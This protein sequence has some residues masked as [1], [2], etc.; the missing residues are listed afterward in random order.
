ML[1][2]FALIWAIAFAVTSALSV[3]WAAPRPIEPG[4]VQSQQFASATGCGCHA[5]LVDQWSTSM[6]AKALEDPIYKVKKAE[7][8][9]ATG[10]QLGAFCDKCHG[11]IATA[12]G[13]LA[14]GGALS[15]VSAQS[16]SC[17]FCHQVI[18]LAPGEPGN[19]SHLVETDGVRRA[20]LQDPAAPHPA[21]YSEFH[22]SA[23][24]CGGCHNVNHPVNGMHLESTYSEWKA[25]AYAEEGIVCQ[26]CHMSRAPGEIGPYTAAAASSAVQRDN[27]YSMMF[28]G[29]QVALGPSKLATQRLK[30]AATMEVNAPEV[31]APG[32]DARVTVTITNSGA[33]HYLP[34]GLTEVRQMWLSVYTESEDGKRTEIG[35][36]RF[37]TVLAD[38]DGKFPAELWDAVKIQSDDRIPPKGSV[39]KSFSFTMPEGAEQATVKA[40]LLYKSTPDELAEKAGVENPVTEMAS[41]KARVYGNDAAKSSA[42]GPGAKAPNVMLLV[43]AIGA[44]VLVALAAWLVLSRRKKA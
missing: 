21:Q 24:I 43:A 27:I 16:V 41:A 39:D 11:P 42:K 8:D 34:T 35:E 1:K 33:G 17:S 18:G 37:G 6:H 29:G 32:E 20:Q 5:Q 22:K 31:V 2:R 28:V 9:K 40:A 30:S 14:A 10:G 36:H 38:K 19:T 12:S 26:D 7:G 15:E 23:E 25:S 44:V 3:A 13:E 4:A